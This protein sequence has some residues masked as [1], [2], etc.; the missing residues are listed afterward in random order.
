MKS[1]DEE[2][3]F[4]SKLTALVKN[5]KLWSH[6]LSVYNFNNTSVCYLDQVHSICH[7]LVFLRPRVYR[8]LFAQQFP[9]M[10]HFPLHRPTHKQ[11][12]HTHTHFKFDLRWGIRITAWP[13]VWLSASQE[14]L[15]STVATLYHECYDLNTAW[16]LSTEAHNYCLSCS[17]KQASIWPWV[18]VNKG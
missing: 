2:Q 5:W 10:K 3:S 17:T 7:F 8:H 11:N 13:A 6:P 16:R 1:C 12:T 15:R 14:A 4:L 18:C 9:L